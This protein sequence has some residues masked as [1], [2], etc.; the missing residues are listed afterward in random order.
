MS[1]FFCGTVGLSFSTIFQHIDLWEK[2]RNV[3]LDFYEKKMN[4][5]SVF[6]LTREVAWVK[7]A[8]LMLFRLL[9]QFRK[10]LDRGTTAKCISC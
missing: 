4:G 1:Y 9:L 2:S 3:H 6:S 5:H 8:T 10:E 7:Y